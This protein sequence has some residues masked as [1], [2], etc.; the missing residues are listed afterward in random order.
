VLDA[1]LARP[2]PSAILSPAPPALVFAEGRP[3]AILARAPDALVYADFRPA[4]ILAPVPD[5]L[6][7]AEG[8]P[9]AILAP[10][11][12]ATRRNPCTGS[13][14]ASARTVPT[15]RNPCTGFAAN[16]AGTASS[17]CT[18]PP[19][20]LSVSS[21]DFSPGR[22]PLS[23]LLR[24]FR[25]P[26]NFWTPTNVGAMA[27]G[28]HAAAPMSGNAG[29]A[30]ASGREQAACRRPCSLQHAMGRRRPPAWTLLALLVSADT[31]A[32]AQQY[33]WRAVL[34]PGGGGRNVDL[35]FLGSQGY[36]QS[37]RHAADVPVKLAAAKVKRQLHFG[38]ADWD[39]VFG[40][41]PLKADLAKFARKHMEKFDAARGANGKGVRAGGPQASSRLGGE[42]WDREFGPFKITD[43]SKFARKLDHAHHVQTAAAAAS[44]VPRA[45]GS[46]AG[47]WGL[48]TS[49]VFN[50]N[51]IDVVP[52]SKSLA[53]QAARHPV[54]RASPGPRPVSRARRTTGQH[55]VQALRDTAQIASPRKRHATG[56]RDSRRK[57]DAH[58]T[59]PDDDSWMASALTRVMED[60][61]RWYTERDSERE[62]QQRG[63]KGTADRS[64]EDKDPDAGRGTRAEAPATDSRLQEQPSRR[65]KVHRSMKAAAGPPAPESSADRGHRLAESGAASSGSGA[66]HALNDAKGTTASTGAA[67]MAESTASRQEGGAH[68]RRLPPPLPLPLA[69][70]G[71]E[72][73]AAVARGREDGATLE[74]AH[75]RFHKA[76]IAEATR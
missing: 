46:W 9:A 13:V 64:A 38:S 41:V 11:P 37:G 73:A 36:G 43:E 48:H 3:A 14:G 55:I 47:G 20:S 6:V 21:G 26:C 56:S 59:A 65:A 34:P 42:G 52:V 29:G 50:A 31:V 2:P 1:F 15:R 67:A 71:G 24:I 75:A 63:R 35:K 66:A 51:G 58:E 69:R 23:G 53:T 7:F 49:G 22:P 28:R 70:G 30:P 44:A 61:H 32:G 33:N 74:G 40:P 68:A 8:R 19:S 39:S 12:D 62:R 45:D 76:P 72:G 18:Q 10:A 4:A 5:A 27:K 17:A 60:D 57:G 25:F 16:G 54:Q